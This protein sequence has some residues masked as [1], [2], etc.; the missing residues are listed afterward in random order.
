LLNSA[1][2]AAKMPNDINNTNA[3]PDAPKA[4]KQNT[5]SMPDALNE[6]GKRTGTSSPR[7]TWAEQFYLLK[8]PWTITLTTGGTPWNRSN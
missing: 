6:K 4:K 3:T 7:N 1:P 8:T 2:D 5:N